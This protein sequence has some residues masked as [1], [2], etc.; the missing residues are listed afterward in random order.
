MSQHFSVL[1]M[2]WERKCLRTTPPPLISHI[3]AG[4]SSNRKVDSFGERFRPSDVQ[5]IF[6]KREAGKPMIS[7]KRPCFGRWLCLFWFSFKPTPEWTPS[8]RQAQVQWCRTWRIASK[9]PIPG[10]LHV[11]QQARQSSVAVF[12]GLPCLV[13]INGN[14]EEHKSDFG[15]TCPKRI[16]L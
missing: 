5:A 15:L 13:V 9:R 6:R 14:Q 2:L 4:Y 16:S 10:I 11:S 1:G 3:S 7:A 8:K 12:E